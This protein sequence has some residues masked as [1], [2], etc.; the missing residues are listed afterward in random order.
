MLAA[1]HSNRIAETHPGR[2]NKNG[3]G[4]RMNRSQESTRL[5]AGSAWQ[6]RLV[7]G[8][9]FSRA[10]QLTTGIGP[11]GPVGRFLRVGQASGSMASRCVD[12]EM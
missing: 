6:D 11:L 1:I 5:I 3:Q 10:D 9:D 7:T 12:D 2:K 4:H 8:H